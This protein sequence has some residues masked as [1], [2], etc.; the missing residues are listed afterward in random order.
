MRR[1]TLLVAA[2]DFT[3]LFPRPRRLSFMTLDDLDLLSAPGRPPVRVTDRWTV[4]VIVPACG[5]VVLAFLLDDEVVC[6]TDK[7]AGQA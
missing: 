7:S 3:Q 4:V 1:A 5:D 6:P 2:V